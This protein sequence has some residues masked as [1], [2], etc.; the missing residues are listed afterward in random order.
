M[1][2]QKNDKTAKLNGLIKQQETLLEELKQGISEIDTSEIIAE[3]NK[4]KQDIEAISG[5]NKKLVNEN[6]KLSSN[7]EA[8][9]TALFTKMANEKLS[10]FKRTQAQIDSYY[11]KEE[12]KMQSRL[13]E[14]KKNCTANIDIMRN[15]I[16]KIASDDFAEISA[17][18]SE[19]EADFSKK[20]EEL[21]WKRLDEQKKLRDANNAFRGYVENEPLTET[22]KRVAVRQKN[23]ETFIGLNILSKAGIVL[24]LIGIIA[25]G[26]FAYTR[27]PDLF[28]ALMI[29]VLGAGL[30]GVG[31]LFHKKE[32]TVFSTAL[33]SGG[34]AVLYAGVAT[35]Y[36]ALELFSV[37]VAFLLCV[38]VTAIAIVLS[39]QLKNQVVCAFG[40]VGGY[41]P[42]VATYMISFGNAAADKT[43]LPVSAVYF[44]LLA[45]II[46]VMTYNKKWYA[47]Q[48]IGYAFQMLAVIGVSSC[49]WMLSKT[50]GYE[51]ALPLSIAFS[52]ASF[53]VYMMMPSVKIVA[54]KEIATPDCVLLALNTISGAIS[55][56][57]NMYN[58]L[59]SKKAVGFTF[60]VFTVIYAFL[61]CRMNT[62]VKITSGYCCKG[63]FDDRRA[64]VFDV[65]S[66]YDIRRGI[67]RN[68]VGSRRCN[69]CRCFCNY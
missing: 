48:F 67:C 17:G 37:K 62:S 63:S 44:C 35:S 13:D 30:I 11:Y 42:L 27:L 32:K 28:K 33:I 36:F 58:L 29:Y 18:L 60:L 55:V 23:I 5:E 20:Q 15:K 52:V 31:E 59:S 22:E 3:N 25:L 51:Y 6:N 21:H 43:F 26:R 50:A 56:S 10:A 65:C 54:R 40:A 34:V 24:F 47:A 53:V 1:S 68:C 14:Y 16:E 39:L 12:N 66:S 38:A 49:S 2:M 46:F 41:L 7:L 57:I 69:N 61:A 19:L 9:K 45:V 64:C 4:L 8:T